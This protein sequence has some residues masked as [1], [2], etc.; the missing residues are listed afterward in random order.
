VCR[1]LG[2]GVYPLPLIDPIEVANSTANANATDDENGDPSSHVPMTQRGGG[3]LS[4]TQVHMLLLLHVCFH[5]L[6]C[7][8]LFVVSIYLMLYYTQFFAAWTPQ[9]IISSNSTVAI[10]KKSRRYY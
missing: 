8:F 6:R 7:T 3:G 4:L 2:Y 5:A 10:P 9:L 1:A